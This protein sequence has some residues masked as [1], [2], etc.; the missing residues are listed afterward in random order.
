MKIEQWINLIDELLNQ[1]GS[2][3]AV[4]SSVSTGARVRPPHREQHPFPD[5]T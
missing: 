4:P 1:F 3:A 5:G 2:G